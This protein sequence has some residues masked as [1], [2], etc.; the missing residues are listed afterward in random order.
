M[1]DDRVHI[2]D[3]RVAAVLAAAAAPAEA[4][5]PGEAAA[6]AAFREVHQPLR[7]N[8]PMKLRENA[9]LL[10]AALFGGVVMASGVATAATGGGF[11]VS[12]DKPSTHAP[13]VD[14]QQGEDQDLDNEDQDLDDD[15]TLDENSTDVQT[16]LEAPDAEN[17][18]NGKGSAVSDVAKTKE[19]TGRNHG[20]DV[21]QV[22]SA[23]DSETGWKCKAGEEHGQPADT[24]TQGQSADK[25][26]NDAD[27]SAA[28]TDH[29]KAADHNADGLSHKPAE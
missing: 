14:D 15:G 7:R 28:R 19:V 1:N 16:D 10:A 27:H 9:K 25:R 26:Q 21:C 12:H 23:D 20:A 17:G 24:T 13:A 6:L 18:D 8:R 11:L 4:P 3:P 22:A 5:L 2:E 29:S